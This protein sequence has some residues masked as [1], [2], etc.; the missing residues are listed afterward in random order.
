VTTR[1]RIGAALLLP[2]ALFLLPS[3]VVRARAQ[4]RDAVV[5]PPGSAVVEGIIETDDA[6]HRPVH[7]AIVTLASGAFGIPQ[8]VATDDA[9]AF[10]FIGV[11][12]GNYTLLATKPAYVPTFYGA[13]RAGSG[14]GVPVAVLE[15][16]HVAGLVLRMPHG[17][18]V[19]G[20]L[21]YANGGPASGVGVQVTPVQV[22]N[23]ERRPG[24]DLKNATTDDRGVYRVFGLAAGDYLVAAEPR[25]FLP[26]APG[27]N[28]TRQV[29]PEEIQWAQQAVGSGPRSAVQPALGLPPAPG[30]TVAYAPVYYPGTSDQS[31]AAVITI[32]A[33]EERSGMDFVLAAVPTARITGLVVGA[34]GGPASGATVTIAALQPDATDVLGSVM[35]RIPGR[36]SPDGTFSLSGVVPGHYRITARAAPPAANGK[37]DTAA[38]NPL[39]FAQLAAMGGGADAAATLWGQEEVTVDGHDIGGISIRLQAGLTVSGRVV[40]ETSAPAD[41]T[42]VRISVDMPTKGNG[43]GEVVASLLGGFSIKGLTPDRY[44]LG[45]S[46]GGLR[47]LLAAMQ[48]GA[49]E[50]AP[51]TLFLKTATWNGR[52]VVDAPFDLKP[53]VDASGMVVTLTDRPTVLS[54]TVR[55]SAGRPTPSYPIV[56]FSTSRAAW[57]A[58]SRRI[59]QA[60]VASDGTFTITGL[61]AGEYFVAALTDLNANE[62]YE[63]AFLES[64]SA[65]SLRITLLDGEKKTQ[66]LKLAGG[67]D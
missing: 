20:A 65:S 41:L 27:S 19:T 43:P 55:D 10:V 24:L 39:L 59:Q 62:L 34:D 61:P 3:A 51:G 11:A 49:L 14:P 64:I 21:R 31:N 9:G 40:L 18:V 2:S 30:Q 50:S 66:D 48:P 7:R 57:F 6:D 4:S 12:A 36:P 38:P 58:G 44:R 5:A 67:G 35:S 56:V 25:P 52:D 45:V 54:G 63:P 37:S 33:G 47:G 8:S 28:D 32:G 22:V 42:Q 29:T 17:S 13:K 46:T 23:G 26:G 15:H 53:G 60:H 16:Q 1:V